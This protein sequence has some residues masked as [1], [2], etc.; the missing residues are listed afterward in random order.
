MK[1]PEAFRSISEVAAMLDVPQHRLR[2]W[3]A[4][5]PFVKPVKR[6]DGRR[7]YRP[8]DIA[9]LAE[10]KR[11]LDEGALS[12]EDIV[13]LHRAGGFAPSH[14]TSAQPASYDEGRAAMPRLR[15]HLAALIAV[16]ARLA[17]VLS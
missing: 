17:A 3:E 1:A 7:Y 12:T 16:R 2:A 15:D 5:F 13:R 6:P 14:A 11:L 9:M 4:R 10:L 8:S